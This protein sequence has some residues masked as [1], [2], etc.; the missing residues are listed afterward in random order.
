VKT[1]LIGWT[2]WLALV[3][4]GVLLVANHDAQPGRSAQ[5]SAWWPWQSSLARSTCSPNLVSFI[6]PLCPCSRASLAE[7]AR[8]H[9]ATRVCLTVVIALPDGL[10]PEDARITL[11]AVKKMRGATAFLDR[12]L[13]ETR[14]FGCFTSGQVLLYS[15]RG[16][17]CYQGG[18]TGSR[19]H[20]GDNA[21]KSA[22][23][24]AVQENLPGL[25]TAPVFGCCLSGDD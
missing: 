21:G 18:L 17:L 10:Q 11:A 16:R 19:G 9:S 14:R 7:L 25:S 22:L 4:V 5:A 23:L 2:V 13:V 6:H 24:A 3:C 20:E 12:N 1:P 15:A 8:V